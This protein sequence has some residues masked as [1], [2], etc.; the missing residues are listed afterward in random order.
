MKVVL[1][2]PIPGVKIPSFPFGGATLTGLRILFPQSLCPSD[3]CVGT[4]PAAIPPHWLPPVN[5]IAS[6]RAPGALNGANANQAPLKMFGDHNSTTG[7]VKPHQ[8]NN[9]S[10][11]TALFFANPIGSLGLE[12]YEVSANLFS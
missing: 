7:R 3:F 4:R 12:H 10:C 1:T 11:C 6:N 5:R 8:Q 9:Q 2:A